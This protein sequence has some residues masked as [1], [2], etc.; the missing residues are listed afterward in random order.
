MSFGLGCSSSDFTLGDGFNTAGSSYSSGGIT[1]GYDETGDG[2]TGS[3]GGTSEAEGDGTGDDGDAD[4]DDSTTGGDIDPSSLGDCDP[5]QQDCDPGLKCGWVQTPEGP[6]TACVPKAEVPAPDGTPC[7]IATADDPTDPCEFGS[8]CG[9]GDSYGVGICTPLC[10]GSLDT[11]GCASE[12][13]LC[14][15]CHNCP[16]VCLTVCDPLEDMCGDGLLCAASMQLEAFVCTV[17]ATADFGGGVND[18]CEFANECAPGLACVPSE[19]LK[20]CDAGSCC[21][22]FCDLDAPSTCANG[23]E[24]TQWPLEASLPDYEHIGVCVAPTSPGTP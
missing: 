4:S 19:F 3:A 11:P 1:D 21:T 24:C 6:L 23:D 9:F 2:T 18:A 10:E 13:A 7:A 22:P 12:D 17:D 14:Q 8:Y 16:S 15:P 20:E 5:F